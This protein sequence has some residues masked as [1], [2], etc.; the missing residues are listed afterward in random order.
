MLFRSEG[1]QKVVVKGRRCRPRRS[2][3]DAARPRGSARGDARNI[4]A[5]LAAGTPD[6]LSDSLQAHSRYLEGCEACQ[7]VLL[8]LSSRRSGVN[9]GGGRSGSPALSSQHMTASS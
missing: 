3:R 9:A 1:N 8:L 2:H 6:D 7:K 5:V 4:G